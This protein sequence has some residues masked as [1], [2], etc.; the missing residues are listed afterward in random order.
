MSEPPHQIC[1]RELQ[2]YL[3]S[4]LDVSYALNHVIATGCLTEQEVQSID[5]VMLTDIE[6]MNRF[7]SVLRKKDERAFAALLEGLSNNSIDFVIKK[8]EEKLNAIKLN[9][10]NHH[11]QKGL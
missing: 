9:P 10:E 11:R 1:L 4:Q 5:H 8:L 3:I 6:K 2:P 7:I